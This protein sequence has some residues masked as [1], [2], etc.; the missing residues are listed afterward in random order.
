MLGRIGH[1]EDALR[2]HPPRIQPH[3]LAGL[4]LAHVVGAHQV[5]RAGLAR[6]H[7]SVAE[8]PDAQRAK[9]VG[10]A[11]GQDGAAGE[12]H[13]RVGAAHLARG[14]DQP[15]GRRVRARERHEVEEDLG[16]ERGLEDRARALEPLAELARVDQVAVVGKRQR[17]AAVDHAQ[18]LGVLERDAARRGVTVVADRER[19]RQPRQQGVV[20]HVRHQPQPLVTV[21]LPAL[22]ARDD[23]RGFLPAVLQRVQPES[24]HLGGMRHPHGAEHPALL[25]PSLLRRP[26]AHGRLPVSRPR[27][28]GA[29]SR[30]IHGSGTVASAN[31]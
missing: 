21:E 6:H 10:I 19:S 20:E 15:L 5:Q 31:R 26:P 17:S 7:V 2:P 9:T 3:Q 1:R 23:A 4:H 24:H 11:K 12:H 25:A 13:Q 8:P 28:R 16:V 18:R 27:V 22:V 14:L 30:S 29:G